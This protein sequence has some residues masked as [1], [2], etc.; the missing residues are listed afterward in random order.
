MKGLKATLT[1]GLMVTALVL[2]TQTAF[3]DDNPPTPSPDGNAGNGSSDATH[4][5]VPG[6]VRNST[7]AHAPSSKIS[8][9]STN[10]QSQGGVTVT[11]TTVLGWVDYG[12]YE[13][14]RGAVTSQVTGTTASH[15]N[16]LEAGGALMKDGYS[17]TDMQDVNTGN[18]A[19]V[20]YVDTGWTSYYRGYNEYWIMTG[21]SYWSIDTW[22]SNM[23]VG[24]SHQF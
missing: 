7:K 1:L 3:A 9:D 14:V 20:T 16:Y 18:V 12:S 22:N 4:P 6:E 17:G 10:H 2:P 11:M 24:A 19:Y 5:G 8:P 23:W 21:H 13:D 15:V